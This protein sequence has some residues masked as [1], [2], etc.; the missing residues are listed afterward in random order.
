M[1][2]GFLLNGGYHLKNGWFLKSNIVIQMD[3]FGDTTS[4]ENLQVVQGGA[5][6]L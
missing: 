1:Y 6:P 3:S 2:E 5:P 4:S